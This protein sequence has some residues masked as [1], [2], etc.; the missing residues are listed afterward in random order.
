MKFEVRSTGR[1]MCRPR[2]DTR[3]RPYERGYETLLASFGFIYVSGLAEE[4]L[5]R[6]HQRLAQRRMRMNGEREISRVRAHLDRQNPLG[7]QLAG[8]DADEADAQQ[9]LGF[10]IENQLRQTVGA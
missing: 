8:A 2:A 3:V 6:F 4:D 9:A 7:N 1:P 10:R 5:G